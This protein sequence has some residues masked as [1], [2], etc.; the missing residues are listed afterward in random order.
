MARIGLKE[1]IQATY[2]EM[3]AAV[4]QLQGNP[5]LSFEYQAIDM[6]F[7]VEM[8]ESKEKSGG[9]KVWVAEGAAKGTS[10]ER[11]TH[12]VRLSIVPRGRHGDYADT[13]FRYDDTGIGR[14]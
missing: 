6:E 3:Y 7:T 4:T 10:E 1:A 13:T 14:V 12:T 5:R 8:S 11:E 9:V 2:D